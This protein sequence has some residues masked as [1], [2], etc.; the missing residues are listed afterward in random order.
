MNIPIGE[1]VKRMEKLAVEKAIS[2]LRDFMNKRENG[3]FVYIAE[4]NHTMVEGLVIIENG[5]IIGSSF[6]YIRFG[7][8][9]NA[10]NALTRFM[11]YLNSKKGLYSIYK[12]KTQQVELFKVFNEDCLLLEPITVVK[13][14]ALLAEF[15]DY[16]TKDLEEFLEKEESKEDVMEKYKITDIKGREKPI[17]EEMAEDIKKAAISEH[18]QLESMIEEYL[19]ASGKP[20]TMEKPPV[21]GEDYPVGH[22]IE[23]FKKIALKENKK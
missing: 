20:P 4:A 14:S 16:E 18:K 22:G 5:A 1:P 3:Y 2:D 10:S 17:E 8:R 15:K 21:S 9:I 23:K 13:L 7:K 19:K 12:W 6:Y 11:S